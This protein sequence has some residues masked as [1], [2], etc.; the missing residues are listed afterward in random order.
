MALP[1]HL[2]SVEHQ[3]L[4]RKYGR[5]RGVRI[6]NIYGTIS[7]TMELLFLIG[8]WISPQ[9]R[10]TTPFLSG[11]SVLI[12]FVNFSIPILHLTVALAF[13]SVGAYFAIW[14]VNVVGLNVAETHGKP[15]KIAA[16]GP[17]SVVRHPQYLG[18]D[19]VHVG[20][21]FLFSAWHSLLFT[22]VY[23][24]YNYL[25]AWMEERELVREFGREY[26][27]YKERVPMFIPRRRRLRG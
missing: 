19:L 4:Q 6:G 25:F 17:Y 23:L 9:P 3:K 5:E 26:E 27:S 1:L 13:V 24:F 15:S 11:Q 12:P 2:R 10:F 22:P 14:A 8:L 7:G 21:S 18:A 20:M 16:K